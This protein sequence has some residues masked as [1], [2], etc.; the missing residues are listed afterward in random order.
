MAGL[1]GVPGVHGLK[2]AHTCSCRRWASWPQLLARIC[3]GSEPALALTWVP[4]L[5]LGSRAPISS[6]CCV[7]SSSATRV[8][9]WSAKARLMWCVSLDR[10]RFCLPPQFRVSWPPIRRAR[11]EPG[12][13]RA[14]CRCL[15]APLA[16]RRRSSVMRCTVPSLSV[17]WPTF[18][19]RPRTPVAAPARTESAGTAYVR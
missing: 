4:G 5:S 12:R 15:R 17:T 13:L 8:W 2:V 6:Y 18:R 14:R 19:S 7:C 11:T 16:S 9:A 10:I 3:C 1:A